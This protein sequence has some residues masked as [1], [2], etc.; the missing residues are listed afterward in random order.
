MKHSAPY[1]PLAVQLS[2]MNCLLG[3]EMLSRM[4]LE[5]AGRKASRLSVQACPLASASP[6]TG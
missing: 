4:A 5:P 6:G 1:H 2:S 3:A